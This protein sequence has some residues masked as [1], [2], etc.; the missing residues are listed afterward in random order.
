[1]GTSVTVALIGAETS[2]REWVRY[3]I[4]RSFEKGNGML[5]IYLHNI[6]DFESKTDAPGTNQFGEITKDSKG[7]SIYFW[8]LYPSYDWVTNNGY[9]NLG[10]WVED[11]AKKAGR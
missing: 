10:T 2:S 6:K 11:A 3:E 4:K 8:E 1:N 5:G 9:Q 7:G